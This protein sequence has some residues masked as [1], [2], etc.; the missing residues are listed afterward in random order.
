MFKIDDRFSC[1]TE[2]GFSGVQ[3]FGQVPGLRRRAAR[4]WPVRCGLG[5]PW[6]LRG[7]LWLFSRRQWWWCL[8][9]SIWCRLVKKKH[10]R[11]VDQRWP[12]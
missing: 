10:R 11:A 1:N 6:V 8:F 9:I 12:L 7:R 3:G 2:T 5:S 4:W